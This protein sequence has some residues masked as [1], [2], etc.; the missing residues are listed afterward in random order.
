MLEVILKRFEKPDEVRTFEKGRFE[1]VKLG[2]MT[3]GRA[4]YEPGW[5]WSVHV[6]QATGAKSC[7]VEHVGMVLSGCATAAMDD[8]RVIEIK[9][10]DVFYI[11]PGHDSWVVGDE[12]Y[13]S[14]H[15]LGAD[16]YARAKKS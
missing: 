13:V 6:G 8:G 7:Q 9:A 15:F 5:K 16:N 1:L 10:G 4:T 12:P 3:I 14:L 2:G 11:A